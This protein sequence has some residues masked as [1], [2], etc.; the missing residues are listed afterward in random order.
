MRQVTSASPTGKVAVHVGEV[1]DS[2][3]LPHT[4]RLP[5]EAEAS[6]AHTT[7]ESPVRPPHRRA[8]PAPHKHTR[9]QGRRD[10][11]A[12]R[13]GGR[14]GVRSPGQEEVTVG[15]GGGPEARRGLR[16]GG[17]QHGTLQTEVRATTHGQGRRGEGVRLGVGVAG[18]ER[19]PERKPLRVWQG[20]WSS[21]C[22]KTP[23]LAVA[24][25][26][27]GGGEERGCPWGGR[28][29]QARGGSEPRGKRR[30]LRGERPRKFRKGEG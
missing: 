9:S 15:S 13:G 3:E 12:E 18:D 22:L 17:A 29:C 19:P 8:Q 28:G 1:V 10:P 25:K 2:G 5:L 23:P 20:A 7:R 21:R 4:H 14:C 24:T 6:V 27:G 16:H 30:G 11:C 26:T